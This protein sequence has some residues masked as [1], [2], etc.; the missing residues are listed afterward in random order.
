MRQQHIQRLTAESNNFQSNH[1]PKS[2]LKN[3]YTMRQKLN[4]QE[5]KTLESLYRRLCA[6]YDHLEENDVELH[7]GNGT[8]ATQVSCSLAALECI[9]QENRED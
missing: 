3:L 2:N 5:V 4:K 7:Y 9:L 1:T 8:A 6:I